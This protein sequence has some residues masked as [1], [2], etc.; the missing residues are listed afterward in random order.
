MTL[1]R[2]FVDLNRAATRRLRE[3]AGTLSEAD[4][5]APIGR[6]WTVAVVFAH[7]AFWDARARHALEATM[8]RGEVV[9]PEV[10]LA[11][12]DFGT[13]LWA[14][15]PP[16]EAARIAIETAEGLDRR[17]EECPAATLA[18]L[19]RRNERLVHRHL[20]RSAH[21]DEIAAALGR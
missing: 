6:D 20:H 19:F 3:L 16:R 5:R 13:P 2:S 7:L 21:L 8:A 18:A 14:A 1:D 9:D 17:L 12:N 15:V 10:D 4:F 11:V